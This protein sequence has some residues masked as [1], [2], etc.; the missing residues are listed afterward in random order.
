VN[1]YTLSYHPFSFCFSFTI[2]SVAPWPVFEHCRLP[3]RFWLATAYQTTSRENDQDRF[4]ISLP[5]LKLAH[6]RR[7]GF[8]A[9]DRSINHVS[10]QWLPILQDEGSTHTNKQIVYNFLE[11]LLLQRL[12]VAFLAYSWWVAARAVTSS[13]TKGTCCVG[14]CL[15]THH[16]ASPVPLNLGGI[17]FNEFTY[18]LR[19]NCVL[20]FI[21]L[22]SIG[23]SIST[24]KGSRYLEHS[25]SG[26]F[27]WLQ[28]CSS[29]W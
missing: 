7:C 20:Q 1:R 29:A 23:S 26:I 24:A 28:Y 17:K 12:E 27:A 8:Y 25:Y 2:S 18:D 10:P 16:S 3:Y 19:S 22:W 4:F 21:L 6:L 15:I 14:V 13:A 9:P 5:L 11:W